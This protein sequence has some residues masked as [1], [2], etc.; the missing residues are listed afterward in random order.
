MSKENTKTLTK[1]ELET[2]ELKQEQKQKIKKLGFS[3]P[4]HFFR[5]CELRDPKAFAHQYFNSEHIG[6]HFHL[7]N[8][9]IELI[10]AGSPIAE[11]HEK[12]KNKK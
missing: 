9:V 11:I 1:T 7:V 4:T 10:E 12:I 8:T 3:S 2:L 6:N 5:F